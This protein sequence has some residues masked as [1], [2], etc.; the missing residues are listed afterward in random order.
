MDYQ[1]LM[2][3]PINNTK[4]GMTS[5]IESYLDFENLGK[6]IKIISSYEDGNKLEKI[7]VFIKGYIKCFFELL[8]N[9]KIQIVHIH[10]ASRGSFYRKKYFLNLSKLFN[11]KVVFHIHGGGF[12]KFYDE[13]SK[14]SKNTI[15]NTLVKSDRVIALSS[16]WKADF[17]YI[18]NNRAKVDIIYNPVD[19]KSFNQSKLDNKNILFMGRLDKRK[20]IYDL[21]EVVPKLLEK[22]KDMKLFIGGDGEEIDEVKKIIESN[23]LSNNVE[24][25]GWISG[26]QKKKLFEISSIYVLP[27]YFEGLPVS[28]LEA[29]ASGLPIVSTNIAGIPEEVDHNL[30]G[31][32]I[33]PGNKSLLYKYLCNLLDDEMLRKNMGQVGVNKIRTEFDNQ[34]IENSILKL[35]ESL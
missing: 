12:M 7:I 10:T 28:I 3:G 16:R 35:Y 33:D 22:H 2:I 18:C 32:L 24:V 4:G 14:R 23:N 19:L 27:S 9:R 21:L 25:L 26:E 11:K 15:I 17:D 13:S 31:Y 8:T 1:V 30:N 34:I 20:G 5:V 29:M 6:N